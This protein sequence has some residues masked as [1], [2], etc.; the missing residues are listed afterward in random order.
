LKEETV[1]SGEDIVMPQHWGEI[2]SDFDAFNNAA[3]IRVA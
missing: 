3:G 1:A 2:I